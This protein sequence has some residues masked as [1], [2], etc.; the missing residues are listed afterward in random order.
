MTTFTAQQAYK[1]REL[2]KFSLSCGLL[3]FSFS[4]AFTL[5]DYMSQLFLHILTQ[6]SCILLNLN[7]I[8]TQ[9][10]LVKHLCTRHNFVF[11]LYLVKHPFQKRLLLRPFLFRQSNLE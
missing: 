9:Y 2:A 6:L 1:F 5:F 4:S 11:L 10:V 3:N 7:Q 8:N